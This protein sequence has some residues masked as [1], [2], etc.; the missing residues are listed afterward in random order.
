MIKHLFNS[1]IVICLAFCVP[2][3]TNCGKSPD[4]WGEDKNSGIIEQSIDITCP[5]INS[6]ERI[7]IT[8]DSVYRKYFD[9]LYCKLPTIDFNASSLLGL[10]ARGGCTM[11]VKRAVTINAE[12]REFVYKVLAKDCGVCRK[13]VINYNWVLVPKIPEEWTVKFELEEK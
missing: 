6:A 13:S 2:L 12:T 4:C 5:Y 7:V 9:T 3:L 11:K 1:P 10:T 8:S